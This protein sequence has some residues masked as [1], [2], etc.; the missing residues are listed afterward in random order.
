M[1]GSKDHEI[2]WDLVSNVVNPLSGVRIDTCKYGRFIYYAS[3]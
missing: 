3:Y 1:S 2:S